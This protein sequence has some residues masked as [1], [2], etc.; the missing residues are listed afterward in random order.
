[1]GDAPYTNSNGGRTEQEKKCGKHNL[2]I[3]GPP[4]LVNIT[5]WRRGHRCAIT[6][7]GPNS[8]VCLAYFHANRLLTELYKTETGI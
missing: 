8:L 6:Y 4:C 3:I 5:C 2:N 1:M 7:G